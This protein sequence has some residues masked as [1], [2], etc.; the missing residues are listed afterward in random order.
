MGW[1]SLLS[2]YI[3]AFTVLTNSRYIYAWHIKNSLI[4]KGYLLFY[5]SFFFVS[6]L[7]GL[8][9]FTS[10]KI[11]KPEICQHYTAHMMERSYSGSSKKICFILSPH[12][13]LKFTIMLL[14]SPLLLW[15]LITLEQSNFV[16]RYVSL[17]QYHFL[18]DSVLKYETDT[19]Y[20]HLKR[21]IWLTLCAQWI[22]CQALQQGSRR[23]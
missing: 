4:S 23:C 15:I 5:C 8:K 14:S 19:P 22:T 7:I 10:N 13:Y 11:H 18:L 20:L 3:Q 21:N 9:V 12:N 2:I 17:I 16:L 1:T 6:Q